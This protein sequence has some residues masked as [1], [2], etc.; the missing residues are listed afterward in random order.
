ESSGEIT[1]L[2][3]PDFVAPGE[4]IC[5]AQASEDKFWQEVY[6]NYD[7]DIHCIDENHISLSGTSMAT[8]HVAGAVAL[9]KQKN[10]QL[11]SEEIKNSLADSSKKILQGHFVNLIEEQILY[12]IPLFNQ[13][14][15]RIDLQRLLKNIDLNLSLNAKLSEESLG[16]VNLELYIAGENITSYSIYYYN[17][18]SSD[19]DPERE[20]WEEIYSEEVYEKE[21][22]IINHLEFDQ[23][24]FNN[25]FALFK[26][27]V[28]NSLDEEFQDYGFVKE[29]NNFKI[30]S[31]GEIEQHLIKDEEKFI[32]S[33]SPGIEYPL[34]YTLNYV[35]LN[36]ENPYRS[37]RDFVPLKRG[38]ILSPGLNEI[39]VEISSLPT[40]RREF[41]LSANYSETQ[42]IKSKPFSV[43]VIKDLGKNG[44]VSFLNI[45]VSDFLPTSFLSGENEKYLV[46]PKDE[47]NSISFG[48]GVL[49]F[50]EINIGVLKNEEEKKE[51]D[52]TFKESNSYLPWATKHE[53]YV[54]FLEEENLAIFD[55]I[56]VKQE[57]DSEFV[58]DVV[59]GKINSEG[60]YQD[61]WPY[62]LDS[63]DFL[64]YINSQ[65][66]I[67]PGKDKVMLSFDSI[68]RG[69]YKRAYD[70]QRKGI[71]EPPSE[72]EVA[73]ALT[74]RILWFDYFGNLLKS[75][76]Y[77]YFQEEDILEENE[78]QGNVGH[79]SIYFN[80]S[81]EDFLLVCSNRY[82]SI[83]EE[84]PY[85]QDLSVE[86]LN[87]TSGEIIQSKK[88]YPKE[89]E[90]F[91]SV[92]SPL[93][94]NLGKET[95][96]ALS[97]SKAKPNPD[98][99]EDFPPIPPE[100]P[101]YFY[102]SELIFLNEKLEIINN[103]LSI[104]D[105]VVYGDLKITEHK[106]KIYLIQN[107]LQFY[108][109]EE[110]ESIFYD[111]E[112]DIIYRT[113]DYDPF[114]VMLLADLNNDSSSEVIIG[115]SGKGGWVS[116]GD[117]FL[118]KI[119][120][121]NGEKIK[122]FEIPPL[123]DY[124]N[125]LGIQ[126]GDYNQD[127][128]LDL[129]AF[130]EHR[131]IRSHSDSQFS[132]VSEE[133]KYLYVFDLDAEYIPENLYSPSFYDATFNGCYKNC[134]EI[135]NSIETP[136]LDTTAPT[137]SNV[138]QRNTTAGQSATFSVLWND[139]T[140]LIPNGEYIFSTNNSGNW[141]NDTPVNFTATPS[142]A[143]ITK[144][145]TS[146]GGIA[147]GY[148]WYASDNASNWNSTAIY[149]F[150]TTSP[151][152]IKDTIAPKYSN[153]GH[154]VTSS[155]TKGSIVNFYSYWQDEVSLTPNGKY[156]FSSN[157]SGV[158]RNDSAISFS[159]ASNWANITKTVNS[160]VKSFGYRW[161]ASDNSSNWNSTAVY[162]ARISDIAPPEEPVIPAPV[163][164]PV[165]EPP[166]EEPQI[167]NPPVEPPVEENPAIPQID[168]DPPTYMNAVHL[169]T[170]AGLPTTFSITWIDET[171][172]TPNGEY[173]FSTDNSGQWINDTPVKFGISGSIT[174]GKKADV[175]V[176]KKL[177][178]QSGKTVNYR[179]Y[180]SD[181]VGNWKSTEAYSFVTRTNLRNIIGRVTGQIVKFFIR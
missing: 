131:T 58:S 118:V 179:W 152:I 90:I 4:K 178:S 93:A 111:L 169:N 54:P 14:S 92:V 125:L 81:Q 127:E 5:A 30:V 115:G 43:S 8:P 170:Y 154:K 76:S 50:P 55:F 3:K 107:Y 163:E 97:L 7:K 130:L 57:E 61:N 68:D 144:I 62:I 161:Y 42:E 108:Y 158:W 67:I 133:K 164:P 37:T 51:I 156:I 53:N 23:E 47:G 176:T 79:A 22:P 171:S 160:L 25:G 148:R 120:S 174:V 88:L 147:V 13:G 41:V 49:S 2:S 122:E 112:G 27:S 145:L 96:F 103:S 155:S 38:L 18:F 94:I 15:G 73:L 165:E 29:I 46:F 1:F 84:P 119:Y 151:P 77:N 99:S 39:T 72:K 102:S 157:I 172:L 146:T 60:V 66:E 85:L 139:E 19:E 17:Q 34:G 124:P 26:L 180:A 181:N 74:K 177:T 32:V 132:D 91:V 153:A 36:K 56:S 52:E 35:V 128:K 83:K 137:Y 65:K 45:S 159:T 140:S 87:L 82:L 162:L 71:G 80:N 101:K 126:L 173:I 129:A 149:S 105:R 28:K 175:L 59:F 166:I 121:F 69:V 135:F 138:E 33:I 16:K 104:Q 167:E 142:W 70:F 12:N 64:K 44:K 21:F 10:P 95:I 106:G 109:S 78:I 63:K 75:L 100:N 114:G 6:E 136:V 11:T 89:D 110:G 168:F 86:I 141:V 123:E 40:G 143:N 24:R 117:S 48:G 113:E 98:Y 31:A 134:Q 116:P 20:V 9:L 150:V